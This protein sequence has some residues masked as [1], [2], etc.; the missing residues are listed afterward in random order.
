MQ[1]LKI[2]DLIRVGRNFDGGYV[3]SEALM[4]QSSVL[5]SFGINDDWSF[6]DDFY[7]KSGVRC[8]GFDFSV[9]KNTFLRRAFEQIRFFFGDMLKRRT[10]DFKRLRES[11]HQFGLYFAFRS[12]IK[13]NHFFS[14]GLD[15][16]SH[17]HFKSLDDIL[18]EYLNGA[19]NIFLKVDIEGYEYVVVNDIVKN[20][21]RFHALAME[22][23]NMHLEQEKFSDFM[24]SLETSFYVYHI[25]ANNYGSTT[26]ENGL[27]DVVEISCIRKDLVHSASFY[28]SMSHL[29]IAGI[30]FP[31]NPVAA[32]FIW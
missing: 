21:D 20:K 22:V 23:H 16:Y 19:K 3:I 32:D 27:P 10:I 31:N 6:E 24:K 14:C 7:L 18:K 28:E 2:D 26:K 9:E 5:L 8:Y 15:S 13:K 30:D 4:K 11:K 17:G 12:F 25:H 1:L 29:P